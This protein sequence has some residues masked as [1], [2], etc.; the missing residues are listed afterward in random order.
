DAAR[1][2]LAPRDDLETQ[3]VRI[4]EHVL[5]IEGVGVRDH[6]FYLC[7]HLFLGVRLFGEIEKGLG[8]RIPLATLFE[9]PTIERQAAI[10]RLR[11]G[12]ATWSSLVPLQP[13]GRLPP[14]FGVH[15]HSGEVLFCRDLS[16]RLGPNQPFF[17]LQAQGLSGAPS[18]RSIGAMATRY[19]EAIRA[20]QPAGPYRIGGY[21]MG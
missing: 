4:W 16:R 10:L 11:R 9:A 14:F 1:P 17:A 3:L 2:T 13:G 7:G 5:G 18:Q 20:V 6:F 15:G 21:C 12:P 8:I 19:I